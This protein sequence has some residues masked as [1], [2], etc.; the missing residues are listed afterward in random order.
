MGA[1][2]EEMQSLHM[3]QTWEFVEHPEGKR[4]IGCK[5]VN[6][7]KEAVSENIL[8]QKIFYKHSF[9]KWNSHQL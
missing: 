3:N 8:T 2:K 9:T 1:M 4:D 5:W 6:K 7:K